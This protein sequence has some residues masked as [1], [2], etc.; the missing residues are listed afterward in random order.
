[1]TSGPLWKLKNHR[2]HHRRRRHYW[3]LVFVVVVA[4]IRPHPRL[5]EGPCLYY[6]QKTGARVEYIHIHWLYC[7]YELET[8]LSK[9][10]L[11][12][13]YAF[14]PYR[15][16]IQS[17]RSVRILRFNWFSFQKKLLLTCTHD[18]SVVS[19]L[20]CCVFVSCVINCGFSRNICPMG[21]G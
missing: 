2:N 10:V 15:L 5:S 8:H 20:C 17:T 21:Y 12:L 6:E 19:F 16:W 3:R 4:I 9:S 11:V 14:N 1:M 7:T 13:K 18:K